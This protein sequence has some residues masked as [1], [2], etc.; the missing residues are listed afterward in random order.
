[1]EGECRP[2]AFLTDLSKAFDCLP[3]NLLIA[4]LNG[5]GFENKTVRFV[6][7]YLTSRKQRNKISDT[8]SSWQEI[9]L[10]VTQGS[11]LAPLLFNIDICDLFFTIKDSDIANF[12]DDN[13][14]YLN[15]KKVEEVFNSLENVFLNLF[16][17]FTEKELKGNASKCHLLISYDENVRVNINISQT[18]N[19]G[20][21][22]VFGIYIDC[23]LSF[24]NHINQKCTKGREKIKVLTR[25]ALFL[26][27][28][29]RN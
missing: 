4:K 10:E 3:H 9:L 23:K 17:W 27:K 11:I 5:Y 7:D 18:E 29:K 22:K 19:S 26:N 6:Y 12:A 24:R 8:Y 21:E 14:L 20:C 25:I 15:Q 1:M 13:T 28:E 2:K 16:L